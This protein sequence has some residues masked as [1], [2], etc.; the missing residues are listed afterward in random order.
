M[1]LPLSPPQ[2]N[3]SVGDDASASSKTLSSIEEAPEELPRRSVKRLSLRLRLK[4]N[5]QSTESGN[6]NANDKQTNKHH[7]AQHAILP[8][9]KLISVVSTN[10]AL[11][12]QCNT[13]EQQLELTS[14]CTFANKLE[15]KCENCDKNLKSVKQNIRRLQSKLHDTICNRETEREMQS[16]RNRIS[17]RRKKVQTYNRRIDQATIG[18]DL[19][20]TCTVS[21]SS[22]V[23][24]KMHDYSLNLKCILG[25]YMIGTGAGDIA[26]LISMMGIC[27]G[28]SFDRQFY[29]SG[30]YVHERILL[31]CRKI[32]RSSLL[33][34][35]SSTIEQKYE[36]VWEEDEIHKMKTMVSQDKINDLPT[37]INSIP[38]SVSYD[39]GWNKRGGG[40]VYDSLSG[41]GFLVGCKTGKIISFGVLKK[42]CVTCEKSNTQQQQLLPHRC[43]VNHSGSSG[44]MESSLALKLIEQLHDETNQKAFVNELVTDDDATTRTILTHKHKK[45]RL[46]MNIP[47][48]VFL[49]D[50]CHR[51]KA[52]VKPIFARVSKTKNMN[53]IRNIDAMRIKKYTSCYIMQNRQGCFKK[54]VANATA[55][56]EHL[57]NNHIYCDSSWCW[58]REIEDKVHEIISMRNNKKV[59]T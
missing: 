59:S 22:D 38:I 50:P 48:P 33:E 53:N 18:S 4:K 34:E 27:G 36:S 16:I 13:G 3:D 10:L 1:K 45:C 39:M 32:V 46:P 42:S 26:T 31:R 14:T 41:H 17:R 35:V 58:S 23:K 28:S 40:R 29:R 44:S 9:S 6:F 8:L 30:K 51:V 2:Y 5:K 15:I 37:T 47:Q 11:C 55:P 43:N 20:S 52:M 25:G 56:I 54:F 24:H 49:A 12:P 19:V 21:P 57:F 7:N